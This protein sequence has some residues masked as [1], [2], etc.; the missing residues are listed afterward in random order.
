LRQKTKTGIE[1]LD[2]TLQGGLTEGTMTLI[3]GTPGTGKTLLSGEFL[4]TGAH[5]KQNG[6][7]VS[8][9][10]GRES[11]LDY[12][13]SVGR[14]FE[15][16]TI[17]PYINI[18]DIV[19]VKETGV[20][21]LVEMITDT[22]EETDTK[23]L[24]ID[25]FTA[26]SNAFQELID[27]RVSLHLLSKILN[28]ANCTT[29][30][31][32]EIPTGSEKIGL[33][34][35]EF[36]ADGIIMLRRGTI[37]GTVIRELE[38]TKM[39][40]TRLTKPQHVYTLDNGF[41]VIQPFRQHPIKNPERY[42]PTQNTATHYSTGNQTLD[43]ITG[44]LRKGDTVY[45]E[46]GDD[47]PPIIPAL[48]IGTLRA[49]FIS[50]HQPVMFLPPGGENIKRIIDFDKTLGITDSEHAEQVRIAVIDHQNHHP[51][52]VKLEKDPKT[53][54]Q[55]WND[56]ETALKQKTSQPIL[57]IIYAD[58]AADI[59]AHETDRFLDRESNKT[60]E[61]ESLLVLLTRPDTE[62]RRQNASNLC[63][64]HLKVTN[65]QGVILLQGI[66]PRTRYYALNQ[67]TAKN[68]PSIRYTPIC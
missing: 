15:T 14:D 57:K 40:G 41:Q 26:L 13:K 27:A 49:N 33:G 21:M 47:I 30:L 63:H 29:L 1:C 5:E 59:L 35:E 24:V 6:L 37:D 60:R 31:I 58:H 4:Y 54:Q 45:L 56:T 66:K 68:H 36:I 42:T 17:S 65:H 55:T 11:F 10:E 39:R 3:A 53:S 32:T 48:I 28:Q 19:A 62:N 61:D 12:M 51:V 20:D 46:L 43:K 38:I 16:D 34:V 9:A 7:Y 18:L 22:I 2:K 23:R 25:S 52:A 64:T 44:G 67:D 8:L 50:N